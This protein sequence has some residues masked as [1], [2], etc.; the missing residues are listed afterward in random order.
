M[1]K[2]QKSTPGQGSDRVKAFFEKSDPEFL[3]ELKRE[4][5]RRATIGRPKGSGQDDSE[6]I[7]FMVHL[8]DG[9]QAKTQSE[10]V[11]QATDRFPGHSRSATRKRLAR[12]LDEHLKAT[13]KT[14]E[15]L[16]REARR[17]EILRR[18]FEEDVGWNI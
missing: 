2:Q 9:G 13:V 10:A 7:A 11:Q 17:A 8:L 4:F 6:A 1:A 12:K 5:E 16:A 15:E 14:P 18:A 3:K